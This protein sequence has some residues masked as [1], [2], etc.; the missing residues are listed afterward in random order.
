M[1]NIW[2]QIL[3]DKQK[4]DSCSPIMDISESITV[5]SSCK[6][7]DTAGVA[8]AVSFDR[9][10]GVKYE[11]SIEGK[12][13]GTIYEKI[14][15]DP[16]TIKLT[17]NQTLIINNYRSIQVPTE[18]MVELPGSILQLA[19]IL[20]DDKGRKLTCYN[21]LYL[22]L[23]YRDNGELTKFAVPGMPLVFD[24]K[25]LKECPVLTNYHDTIYTLPIRSETYIE[26]AQR[27]VVKIG[28]DSPDYSGDCWR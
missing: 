19:L 26:L 12:I 13:Y 23:I 4:K 28:E 14:V 21:A 10:L 7:V 16:F 1:K 11:I 15:S 20:D 5:L 8:K 17:K 18:M 27:G 3:R 24:C 22:K 2:Q 9:D 6:G 25:Q